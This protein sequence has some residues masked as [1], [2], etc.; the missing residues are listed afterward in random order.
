MDNILIFAMALGG[1][2][3]TLKKT[4]QRKKPT[5]FRTLLSI[6]KKKTLEKTF[7][8]LFTKNLFEK[9]PIDMKS[10]PPPMLGYGGGGNFF[11]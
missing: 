11:I 5:P 1:G 9:K 3:K 2:G 6:F 8:C 10:P 7:F 4:L